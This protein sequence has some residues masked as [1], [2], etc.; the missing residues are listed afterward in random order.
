MFDRNFGWVIKNKL[1]GVRGPTGDD[2]LQFLKNEGISVLVRLAEEHKACVTAE[3]VTKFGMEDH[4]FPVPDF[5]PPSETQ[6]EQITKLV[7][8]RL[9]AGQRVAVSCGAGIGRTGTTLACILI[10]LCNPV[11]EAFEILKNVEREAFET[12]D[13]RAA[14]FKFA[15]KLGKS[16]KGNSQ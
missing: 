7:K 3:Q 9:N 10:S 1:A 15:Q 4:H 8:D 5:T 12:A 13:Q 6:I 14:I 11:E 16:C 2:D